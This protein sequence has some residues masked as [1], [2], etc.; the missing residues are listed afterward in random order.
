MSSSR[1]QNQQAKKTGGQTNLLLTD[2]T[3]EHLDISTLET[4][5]WDAAPIEST[6][7]GSSDS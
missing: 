6:A 1:T 4:W 2:L 3:A 5:L 7:K